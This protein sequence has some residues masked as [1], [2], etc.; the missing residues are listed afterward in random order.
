MQQII[1]TRSG[2]TLI[3]PSPEEE[4]ARQKAIAADP[5]TYELA[6]EELANLK[7]VGQ[8]TQGQPPNKSLA[9]AP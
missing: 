6:D 2:Q 1:N 9:A 4:T 5:D 3:L 8:H 7:T